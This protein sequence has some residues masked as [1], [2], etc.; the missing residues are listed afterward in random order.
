MFYLCKNLENLKIPN[1]IVKEKTDGKNTM[2]L[3]C[4]YLEKNEGHFKSQQPSEN[5]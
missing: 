2:L 3:G 4:K 5:D 1:F